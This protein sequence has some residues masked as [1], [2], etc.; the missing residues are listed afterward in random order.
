MEV[1]WGVVV[2]GRGRERKGVSKVKW[3]FCGGVVVEGQGEGEEEGL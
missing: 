3:K 2:V 1:L